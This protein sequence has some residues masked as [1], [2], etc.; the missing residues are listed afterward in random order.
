MF[1]VPGRG[2]PAP[3]LSG[4]CFSY[5]GYSRIISG[6]QLFWPINKVLYEEA[7]EIS[8]MGLWQTIM[9]STDYQWFPGNTWKHLAMS[10]CLVTLGMVVVVVL[11]LNGRPE[12]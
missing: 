3:S 7:F 5:L 2:E 10:S 11:I 8:S 1:P 12:M 4:S 6:I 9:L